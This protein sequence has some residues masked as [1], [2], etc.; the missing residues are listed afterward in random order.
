MDEV[1][2]CG[3][4]KFS[5]KT[6]SMCCSAQQVS[7][8]FFPPLPD[9]RAQLYDSDTPDSRHFLANIR[10][11]N[12]AFQM[13]SFEYNEVHL[14]GW[15][16]SFCMQGQVFHCIR[17]LLPQLNQPPRF[18]Q[19]YFIDNCCEETSTHMNISTGL[20]EHI[21]DNLGKLLHQC[22]QS[23]QLLKTAWDLLERDDLHACQV[24]INEERRP[25]GDHARRL[26]APIS[27]EIGILMPN[28]LTH[29][30]G[31]VLQ[32]RNGQLQHVSE[33]H[34]SYD[35][36][37]YPLPFPHGT[38]GYN[39][40]LRHHNGKKVTQITCYAFHTMVRDANH[41]LKACCLFQQFL[42]DVYCIIETERLMQKKLCVDSY[43]E[44]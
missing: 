40:Y 27:N 30:W 38:D 17:S 29:N 24:V 1:C 39:I 21:V 42:V 10:K 16:P 2:L 19:V 33:L 14:P 26:N 5:G 28:E 32:Y 6:P 37:Q 15:N 36:L 18:L 22:N 20:K 41:L 12:C 8:D 7:F 13:T 35:A 44:L 4:H 34:R 23:V 31:I 3:A 43:H 25:P 11:Y 9:Y